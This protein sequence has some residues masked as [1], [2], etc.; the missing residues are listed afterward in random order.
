M[1]K[2]TCNL[3]VADQPTIN[4]RVYTKEVMELMES[5]MR[6]MIRNNALFVYDN[7]PIGRGTIEH[8]PLDK[9]TGIV[10]DCKLTDTF[11]FEVQKL[12]LPATKHIDLNDE[13]LEIIP[14]IYGTVKKN[15][16][17][18]HDEVHDV[19]FKYLNLGIKG[20]DYRNKNGEFDN[21]E[22]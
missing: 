8:P 12:E 13:N 5:Q 15:E 2:M 10:S 1:P 18:G 19:K 11:E 22:G 17:T 16:E 21:A 14:V 3:I 4:G 20:R 7:M 6:D 9:I